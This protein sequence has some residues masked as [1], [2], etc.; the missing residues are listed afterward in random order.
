M[1]K[2]SKKLT[3]ILTTL[4]LTVSLIVPN[5]WADDSEGKQIPV[6]VLDFSVKY[7]DDELGSSVPFDEIV[8]DEDKD[9]KLSFDWSIDN[10]VN[11]EAG[12]YSLFDLPK[13]FEGI[14]GYSEGNVLG[15]VVDDNG[16]D[17]EVVIG[18]WEITDDNKLKWVY[19]DQLKI[20]HEDRKGDFFFSLK[21]DRSELENDSKQ[22]IIF[23]DADKKIDIL[24][25]PSGEN[26]YEIKKS[27]MP[28]QQ[29]NA[30][31]ITWT[32]YVNTSLDSLVNGELVDPI[33]DGLKLDINSIKVTELQVGMDG[34]IT[35]L[36]TELDLVTPDTE[37]STDSLLNIKLGSTNKAYKVEFT[38]TIEEFKDA[39]Y[40]NTAT[41]KSNND[42]KAIS[43]ASVKTSQGTVLD[44]Q[45]VQP[46]K[47]AKEITWSIDVNKSLEN[48][49]N[50]SVEDTIPDGLTLET[51][52]VY[53]L[54][55]N[56]ASDTWVQG[57]TPITTSETFPVAL[58]DLDSAVRLVYT[59]TIDTSGDY[60]S[61]KSFTNKAQLKKDDVPYG[62][63]VEKTAN[64][65]RSAIFEKSGYEFDTGYNDPRI[66]WTLKVNEAKHTIN[67]VFVK[68][69]IQTGH[70]LDSDSLKIYKNGVDVTD[71]F[72]EN[73]TKNGQG[74]E[75]N[76]G[77]IDEFYEVRYQTIITKITQ[78]SYKNTGS[79]TGDGIGEDVIEFPSDVGHR[80]SNSYTKTK[81]FGV[82]KEAALEI[83][84]DNKLFGWQLNI[85]TKK[86]SI[87]D[88][89][90]TD[91]FDPED[92]MV[93]LPETLEVFKGTG[94]A[95]ETLVEDT[96][97][98]WNYIDTEN[99]T[100]G[101]EIKFKIKLEKNLYRISYYTSYDPDTVIK[102][103]GT[104]NTNNDH[105]FKN[106]V[107][108]SG[109]TEKGYQEIE[110]EH[111]Y[112]IKQEF[113]EGGNKNVSSVKVVDGIRVLDWT[114]NVNT[115]QQ[116]LQGE[117]FKINDSLSK[118]GNEIT[119]IYDKASIKVYKN[120][121]GENGS[122]TPDKTNPLVE[123]EGK[124]YTI[125][126]NEDNT[127]FE[128]V[129]SDGI[130]DSYQVQYRTEIVGLSQKTYSN[131]VEVTGKDIYEGNYT[132]S[133]TYGNYNKFVDKKA[134]DFEGINKAYTDDEIDWE[135]TL[136]TSLSVIQNAVLRDV[137]STGHVYLNGSL[138]IKEDTNVLKLG[139]DYNLTVN[140][141]GELGTE[142]LISFTN[143]VTKKLVMNYTTVVTATTGKI[144]N[145]AELTG[146]DTNLGNDS[147]KELSAEIFS[148]GSATGLRPR[149][150]IQISK[151]NAET[152]ALILQ[153]AEFELSYML[154]GVKQI[155]AGEH[156]TQNGILKFENLPYRTYTL[157][158]IKA[159]AG[160]VLDTEAK[161]FVVNGETRHL[162]YEF[163]NTKEKINIDAEKVWELGSIVTK[164][165]ITFA[166][167]RSIDGNEFEPVLNSEKPVVENA[168][169]WI[170]LDKTNDAGAEYTYRV[171]ELKPDGTKVNEGEN[172]NDNYVV[173]Y[174][175]TGR[176]VTNTYVPT[177]IS[178][179][180]QKVWHKGENFEK[181][182]I[183][184]QIL[185][186]TA[187]N[188][189][190]SDFEAFGEAIKDVTTTN[191]VSEKVTWEEL[192]ETD[193]EG[194]LYTYQVVELNE[195]ETSFDH[196]NFDST[197]IVVDGEIII[198]N[199]YKS[200]KDSVE[201]TK[202]WVNGDTLERP[203]VYFKLYR[204]T[205]I[206]AVIGD[207]GVNYVDGTDI[208]EVVT[209]KGETEVTVTWTELDTTD[210]EGK[211]Y[212]YHVEEVNKDGEP[213]ELENYVSEQ[214]GL[215]VKNTYVIPTGEISAKKT[216]V[217]GS[218]KDKLQDIT[219]QLLQ[220]GE[221]H[222]EPVLLEAGTYTYTWGSL[223]L[224]D[225]T[226]RE[227]VYTVVEL[228]VPENYDVSYSGLEI[229]NTYVSPLTSK[230]VKKIWVE[231]PVE[232]DPIEVQLYRNGKPHLEPVTLDGTEEDAW[233]HT[234]D[235]LNLNDDHGVEYVYSVQE[236]TEVE[237]FGV[238][239]TEVDGV[240][241]IT[242]TFE[243]PTT[244]VIGRKSWV[245]GPVVKPDVTLQLLRN[246]EAHLEP[247][248]LKSGEYEY[249]WLDLDV[250]DNTGEPYVYTVEEVD[251]PENYVATYDGMDVTNTYVIP[252]TDI[253]V[254][255]LWIH[256]KRETQTIGVQLYR[257]GEAFG[258][259]V[260]LEKGTNTYTWKDLDLTD[261]SGNEYV[262][263][264]DEVEVP[265][266]YHKEVH[267]FTIINTFDQGLLDALLP[268]PEEKP[269]DKLP[270][271][272]AVS[273][274]SIATGTLLA[275]GL[276]FALSKKRKED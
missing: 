113:F 5:A 201:A 15:V 83:D 128:L 203:I 215:E 246:G 22:E 205:D 31:E 136:N 127:S 261:L 250:L 116:N 126:F 6:N 247:V 190:L 69:V 239:Y 207:E 254:E 165:I 184:F 29:T 153:E 79:M 105:V 70:K 98:T 264:V 224:T 16:D 130:K 58:E 41:L 148:G 183:K 267:G 211:T 44:K 252:V 152:D 234:W 147:S 139:N 219:L 176:I 251:V 115:L 42:V 233:T 62:K 102:A 196:D 144:S 24:V 194:N 189:E 164:P 38:T 17:I 179:S 11:L 138:V 218:E 134:I 135:I 94:E 96:H 193:N 162:T 106:K 158:E 168:A 56:Q 18:T 33:P 161:E 248:V 244:S 107:K 68:D 217:G 270:L 220:D 117:A 243:S 66:Q 4:V 91:T 118:N 210:E 226:G 271:T 213:L 202:T 103:G 141:L 238:E 159:P 204:T 154:N 95:P 30:T 249:I 262:Y 37:N 209:P 156:K 20:H 7:G 9:V 169:S 3:S 55:Y 263:T 13:A 265:L 163:K 73:I 122:I 109:T 232:K 172:L 212:H 85:D 276:F 268:K 237:N 35:E 61:N 63:E 100:K 53:P 177:K 166:L 178:V 123:G 236:V 114:L 229:T 108:F 195:D 231:G 48:L 119:Q 75:I 137:I 171:I 27:G 132:A 242:N 173:K 257:N 110:K 221:P 181:P 43:T 8:Y 52:T 40:S 121:I 160:F 54:V 60:W 258:D 256:E 187:E 80:V 227:Y 86:E 185:R 241:V 245:N 71:Q 140:D 88:M 34:K 101:F 272:G 260:R 28:N 191:N 99:I 125:T 259:V 21:F 192:P 59:T 230:S 104:I 82:G 197:T 78:E 223:E 120:T 180:A 50:V 124:D 216:W 151:I 111:E 84:Y 92:S 97:Y 186:T 206:D 65:S 269:K 208:L 133:T 188:P 146:S 131:V 112:T 174:D 23:G 76:F 87:T 214:D 150:S 81:H 253:T 1:N 19:N 10:A 198:T 275:S 167:E 129:L 49:G 93:F 199:T 273:L 175:E 26:V 157:K 45:V 149:G 47:D 255:K 145:H 235:E 143:D 36:D 72:I 57:A 32:V 46:A 90:V 222:D 266:G 51:I 225:I 2:I 77:N 64:V 89:I 12:D 274:A 74:F 240:F 182:T 170:S 39:G 25:K 200:S 67:G 155:V 228:D 142:L 14:E